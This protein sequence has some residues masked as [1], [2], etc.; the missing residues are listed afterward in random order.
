LVF[1][2]GII[3][4]LMEEMGKTEEDMKARHTVLE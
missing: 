3:A 4:Q 1:L 2:D